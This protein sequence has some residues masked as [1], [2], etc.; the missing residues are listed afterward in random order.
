MNYK[1]APLE[2]KIVFERKVNEELWYNI[3]PG[4]YCGSEEFEND[5]FAIKPYTYNTNAEESWNFWHKPSGF[6]IGWYKNPM[7]GASCNF[8]IT[9]QQFLDI[10][11]DCTNSLDSFILH[12]VTKWWETISPTELENN[13]K[14]KNSEEEASIELTGPD[15]YAKSENLCYEENRAALLLRQWGYHD[16]IVFENYNYDTAFVGVTDDGRAVYEYYK[17]VEWLE[18]HTGWDYDDCVDWIDYN[19]LGAKI[20]NGPIVI[21]NLEE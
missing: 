16:T 4:D 12:Q 19:T 21:Y 9:S 2:C 17:M 13:E 11:Y 5:T 15:E 7:K 20:E 6:R 18:E 1:N 14:I 8:K 10:L 3:M